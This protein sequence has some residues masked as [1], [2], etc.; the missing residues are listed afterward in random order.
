ME[1]R[2]MERPMELGTEMDARGVPGGII[3]ENFS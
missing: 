1:G 2:A 3:V